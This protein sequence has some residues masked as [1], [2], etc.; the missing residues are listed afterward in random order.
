MLLIIIIGLI[1]WAIL[2]ASKRAKKRKYA[3]LLEKYHDP[4]IVNKIMAKQ[5]WEGMTVEQL[6]DSWGNPADIG[7]KVYK[8]KIKY[9]WKYG[10]TGRNRYS[11]R[12]I[13]EDNQVSGW[14]TK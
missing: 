7:E 9:T 14:E 5:I 10:Q 1:I 12:V 11:R 4:L 8:A 6:R 2:A 3:M 13:I